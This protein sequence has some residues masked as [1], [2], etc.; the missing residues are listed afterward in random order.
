MDA[1]LV[2][3]NFLAAYSSNDMVYIMCENIANINAV[4]LPLSKHLPFV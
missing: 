4:G 3:N 1:I 2:A